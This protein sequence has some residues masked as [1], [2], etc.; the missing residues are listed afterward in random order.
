MNRSTPV[1]RWMPTVANNTPTAPAIR[2]LRE[3]FPVIEAS[4]ERAK[5]ANAKY[6]GG[7]NSSATAARVGAATI[8]IMRLMIPPDTEETVAKPR[9]RPGSPRFAIG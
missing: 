3:L 7:R 8:N 9:A 2:F 4:I 1:V 5:T 6:S